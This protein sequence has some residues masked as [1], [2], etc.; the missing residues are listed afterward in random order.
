VLDFSLDFVTLHVIST[1]SF[2]LTYKY[3]ISPAGTPLQ[4]AN[5]ATVLSTTPSLLVEISENAAHSLTVPLAH[6]SRTHM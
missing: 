5:T 3:V 4:F 6:V 2:G 1:S